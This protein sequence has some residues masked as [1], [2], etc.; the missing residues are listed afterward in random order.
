MTKTKILVVEDERIV[1]KDIQNSLIHLGYDVPAIASTSEEAIKAAGRVQPDLV[2]MDIVLKGSI[3]GIETASK[4]R[5][6]YGTPVIYL[7]AYEDERTLARAKLTEPLG[8]I[9]KPFEERDL[10]TTLEMALYKYQMENKLRESEGHYRSLVE[11]SPEGIGVQHE[12]KII[13]INPSG[14][15]L[16]GCK[17]EDEVLGKSLLNFIPT[18]RHELVREKINYVEKNAASLPFIEVEFMR[19]NGTK[20]FVDVAYNPFPHKKSTAVQFIFRDITQRKKSEL[21]LKKAYE[22]LKETHLVLIQAE[23]L[24]ALGRFSSGIAHEIRNPLANISASAQIC[25]SKFG[26]D[27]NL[28]RHFEIIL[29]NT[30]NANGIIKELL[31]FTSPREIDFKLEDITSV[32]RHACTLIKIRC[33]NQKVKLHIDLGDEMPKIMVNEKKLEE[34]MLNFISNAIEAM[35]EGGSLSI[36]AAADYP[37][38]GIII[39]ISDS[40]E[41]IPDENKDKVFEPFFTTKDEGTGLGMSLSYQIIKSHSGKLNVISRQ[42]YGTTIEIKLPPALKE[43]DGKRISTKTKKEKAI[44]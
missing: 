5:E 23:K 12:D 21:E 19:L 39:T 1:A 44:I 28:K 9:L 14:A 34:A 17:N 22:D 8:Y 13:F 37:S 18:E 27:P 3:D 24:A 40:G 26:E 20:F 11:R 15:K 32:L 41:G 25:M 33:E 16:L 38:G 36:S 35:P 4:I 31:D 2:L 30:D 6:L 10:H 7:T 29:R 43:S 42:G